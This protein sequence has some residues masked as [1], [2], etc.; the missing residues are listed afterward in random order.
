MPGQHKTANK[1][2]S[3]ALALAREMESRA[4]NGEWKRTEQLA[5]QIRNV[6]LDI[7]G[8]ERRH[9]LTQIIHCIEK[10]Q[11][12]A[13]SSRAEVTDKLSGLRRGRAAKRAYGQ[14]ERPGTNADLP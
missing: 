13:L 7:P 10:V 1:V 6:V 8:H 5:E 14:P 2:E 4:E 12:V 11:T 9:T 3:V